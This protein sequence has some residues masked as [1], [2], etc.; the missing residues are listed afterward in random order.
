MT[1]GGPTFFVVGAQKAGTTS[2]HQYLSGHPGVFLPVQKESEF[3]YR[4][5]LYCRGF[6]WYLDNFFSGATSAQVCGEVCPQYMFSAKVPARIRAAVPTARIIMLL[7]NPIAR[8]FSHYRMSLRRGRETRAFDRVLLEETRAARSGA[9][10]MEP[11]FGYLRFGEYGRILQEYLQVFPRDAIKV[12]F[13]EHLSSAREAVF[14]EVARFIGVDPGVLPSALERTFNVGGS[15]RF[16]TLDRWVR[17]QQ[18]PKR[19]L[20]ALIGEAQYTRFWFWYETE[21]SVRKDAG[22]KIS[23]SGATLLRDYFADD[24]RQLEKL[25]GQK[26]PWPEFNPPSS[27]S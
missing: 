10:S 8:A 1:T 20:R 24:V 5:D 17:R 15:R 14:R 3:F 13:A 11:D 6:Q 21:F 26:T 27:A 7:R 25:I 9:P 18:L 2:L 22:E 19:I 12:I 23:A 4:D 16:V